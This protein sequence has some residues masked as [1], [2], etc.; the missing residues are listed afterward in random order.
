M[1]LT[2][3]GAGS[4]KPGL[5]GYS[6]DSPRLHRLFSQCPCRVRRL[7]TPLPPQIPIYPRLRLAAGDKNPACKKPQAGFAVY[8]FS[9]K[10]R[11]S[12]LY[13]PLFPIFAVA[14]IEK[15]GQRRVFHDVNH[16]DE[17]MRELILRQLVALNP[18]YPALVG[19]F[20]LAAE[21]VGAENSTM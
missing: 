13:Y 1:R 5:R 9:A 4:A 20:K 10:A 21:A 15:F 11:G 14:L 16:V 18:E 17:V 7:D 6:A 19:A 8:M 12:F 3:R 2:C